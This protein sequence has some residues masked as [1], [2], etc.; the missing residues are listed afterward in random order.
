[1]EILYLIITL[2]VG[3]AIGVTIENYRFEITENAFT[4][5]QKSISYQKKLIIKRKKPQSSGFFGVRDQSI[6]ITE[7]LYVVSIYSL[8][9]SLLRTSIKALM[10]S[11]SSLPSFTT[12][13]FA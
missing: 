3:V 13:T 11:F 6:K 2:L 9:A 7:E 1:M 4:F 12:R 8:I 10:P 5:A